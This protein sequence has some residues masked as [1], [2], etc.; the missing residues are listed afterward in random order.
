MA[1]G[2]FK[3]NGYGLYDMVGNVREWVADYYAED[4]FAN[5]P[6]ENPQG[7]EKTRWRMIKGGGWYSG[8]GCNM[9]HVAT[10]CQA[11]GVI[12][13]WASAAHATRTDINSPAVTQPPRSGT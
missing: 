12:S 13:T 6:V 11:V 5:S 10:P 2:S 7:P 4:Y 3:P 9:V 8:K 1:V